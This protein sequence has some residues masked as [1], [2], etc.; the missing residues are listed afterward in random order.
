MNWKLGIAFIRGLNMFNTNRIK[1]DI[2]LRLVKKI[3]SNNI[4]ILNVYKTDN[5]IFKVRSLPYAAVGSKL[6]RVF[7]KYFRTKIYVT[8]RGLN[9]LKKIVENAHI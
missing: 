1:K 4:K 6:E 9:T 5:V 2:V 7:S 3:E 8:T